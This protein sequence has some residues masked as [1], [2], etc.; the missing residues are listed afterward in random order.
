MS[1]WSWSWAIKPDSVGYLPSK[2]VVRKAKKMAQAAMPATTKPSKIL[3]TLMLLVAIHFF[4]SE[5][6]NSPLLLA[7]Q[8]CPF[9]MEVCRHM[10]LTVTIFTTN[11]AQCNP[12]LKWT[13]TTVTGSK[14]RVSWL[15]IKT[16]WRLYW[17]YTWGYQWAKSDFPAFCNL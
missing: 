15:E 2:R 14:P 6:S 7:W 11:T 12:W 17:L 4:P 9:A 8:I 16:E 5:S 10:T 1:I 13:C 3:L